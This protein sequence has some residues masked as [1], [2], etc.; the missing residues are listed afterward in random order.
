M[1]TLT[2]KTI[3]QTVTLGTVNSYPTYASPLTITASGAVEPSSGDAIFGPNAGTVVNQGTITAPSQGVDL[4]GSGSVSN[5]GLIEGHYGVRIA[6]VAGTVTNSGSIVGTG[7]VSLGVYVFAGSS[8]DNTGVI[9]GAEGVYIKAQGFY[10]TGTVTST[11]TNSGTILSMRGDPGILIRGGGS[12]SN[13]GLIKA[14]YGVWIQSAN[15]TVT[16]S[17]T[18]VSTGNPA[19]YGAPNPYGG[20]VLLDTGGSVGNTGLIEGV[21]GYEGVRGVD[22]GFYAGTIT[23]SGMI[24]GRISLEAGGTLTN[25][26]TIIA[27]R[28][29][30]AIRFGGGRYGPVRYPGAGSSRLVLEHGY[31]INGAVVGSISASN[32]VELAGSVGAPLTV[33]YTGLGLT[34]FQDVLFGSGGYDTL[35]T[36][37]TAGTL[38]ATISGFARTSDIIDLTQIGTDGTIT[39]N[40]TV[41]HR[42]TVSGSGGSVVLQLDASDSTSFTTMSDGAS[43][44]ELIPCFCRGTMILT[45][46]GEVPVEGLAI[47]DNVI[48]L[49]EAARPIKWI[50]KR[51]YDPRFVEGNRNLLPIRI[52][53]GALG[54]GVPA[55]D[56]WISPEHA[57]CLRQVLVPAQLLVN[58][59]TITQPERVERL[60]YFHIDLGTHDVILAEGVPAESYVDCDNRGMFHNSREFARLYPM[61]T[62]ARW[63]FCTRRVEEGSPELAAI[64]HGV[65]ARVR[66][67]DRFTDDPDLLLIVDGTPIRP[68]LVANRRLYRFAVSAGSQSVVLASRSTV[69]AKIEMSSADG[70]RLGVAVARIVLR[71]VGFSVEIAPDC[72]ALCNGFHDAEPGCRWTDGHGHLPA[73]LFASFG[74]AFVVEV[75]LAETE[76]V[77][78]LETQGAAAAA[79]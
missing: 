10:I 52:E 16:N 31:Y 66:V 61:E 46:R 4:S 24:I 17:G 28:F 27:D 14:G 69:P 44:T 49:S 70:R 40:D 55:R 23:N 7:S 51:A 67:F 65:L 22:I 38:P 60:E 58:D 54:P 75:N 29:G 11:V 59:A 48:T 77:Y 64:R 68:Q 25:S 9:E 36:S 42:V 76:F 33:N 18:I 71:G 3:T 20:G 26:G 12:I 57:L 5:S 39:N 62:P 72:P 30:T 13:T 2:N 50:G 19:A 32:T 35:K 63:E 79:A 34:N 56:L 37:R 47:G 73:G 1:S 43:G 41:G 8:V 21:A 15:A 74:G 6:A 45:E 53:A 78:G